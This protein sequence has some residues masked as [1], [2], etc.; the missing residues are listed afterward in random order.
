M[1]TSQ[2]YQFQGFLV[3]IL[4]GVLLGLFYDFF[5]IYRT[6]FRPEKRA[7]FFQ[8]LFYMAC[9]ALITFLVSVGVNFGEVRFYILAGEAIGWCLYY[10]TI[11]TVTYQVFRF[12]S[13]ILRKYLIYPLKRFFGM[14]FRWIFKKFNLLYK[15]VKITIENQKKRLKQHKQIVYNQSNRKHV[16]T[17]QKARKRGAGNKT[18]KIRKRKQAGGRN[19][20]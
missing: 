12:V 7:V 16:K 6:V 19:R 15:N 14:I 1:Y 17:K 10:L 11:G 18:L 13:H 8:D 20:A 4:A 9:A 3:S 5:R 2:D